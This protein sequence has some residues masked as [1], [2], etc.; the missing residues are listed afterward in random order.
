MQQYNKWVKIWLISGLVLIFF[1]VVIGGV[2]R[3]TGSG[4]S[5]TKW[6]IVTGTLPPMNS[7]SWD[8]EFE[9]YKATPQYKK[10][11]KG[12]TISEFKFIYFW[13]Y[14]HRLW[15]RWM[16]VIFAIPFAI[17]WRKGML[18]PKVTR[19]LGVVFL[20]AG[21]AAV[22]GWVMVASGLVERPW[23]NAYK[24]SIHLLI[25]FACFSYL[26]WT[27]FI[28][29]QGKRPRVNNP[30]AKKLFIGLAFMI[31]FQIFLGGMMSGMK[32]A[33]SFPTWPSYNGVSVPEVLFYGE[34]WNVDNFTNYD[35]SGFM[36]ALIQFLHRNLAYV[37]IISGICLFVYYFKRIN[38]PQFRIGNILLVT[39]LIIQS[40]LGIST[41]LYT[42]STIPVGL[43]VLH[44]A[45]SLL[46]LTVVLWV[47]FVFYRD[48]YG[49]NES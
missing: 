4:L 31:V 41:L 28:V 23:V 36:P 6:E 29:F 33:L 24:L 9:L 19:R 3:L 27:A 43:G 39:M 16:F 8:R 12:M 25:A 48:D 13:E 21:L 49:K 10:I 26:L 22:F 34:F 42:E 38:E 14:F 2:T 44:Q 7:K 20:L 5:I 15:A 30:L 35:A 40:V 47:L 32:A 1:Q 18:V 45:G 46:L 37:L 11:N 17:F